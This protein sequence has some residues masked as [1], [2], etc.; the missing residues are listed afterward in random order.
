[1]LQV[2][3]A[4]EET[5]IRAAITGDYGAA[6]QAF[7]MNPLVPAGKTAKTL[8]DQLLYAHKE[9]LPQFADKIAEI[10]ADQ[11]EDVKYIDELMT[12]N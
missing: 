9:H 8:L 2:M 3:K 5:T 4:M 10:E 12:T 6:L 7:T 1:M 11:P